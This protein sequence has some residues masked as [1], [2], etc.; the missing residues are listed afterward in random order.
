MEPTSYKE[1]EGFVGYRVGS[2]GTVWT[3]WVKIMNPRIHMILGEEWRKMSF[4]TSPTGYKKVTLSKD[5]KPYYK[6]AHRLVLEAFVGPCPEGCEG[7]HLDNNPSNNKLENLSWQTKSENQQQR[8]KF[9]TDNMGEN[10]PMVKITEDMVRQIRQEIKGLKRHGAY[11]FLGKKY[12]L[13]RT[14]ISR[15]VSK[16]IWPHVA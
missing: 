5:S 9:G 16:K 1:I 8:M 4:S 11:T 6:L 12:G 7:G 10:H 3:K 2:D 13:Y 14:T 15:I